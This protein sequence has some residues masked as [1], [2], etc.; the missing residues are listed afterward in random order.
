MLQCQSPTN[1]D[2]FCGGGIYNKGASFD[3]WN[4]LN[5]KR[6]ISPQAK[7]NKERKNSVLYG[8]NAQLFKCKFK[9]DY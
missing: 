6:C 8:E 4:K 3:L 2:C 5:F 9:V 7:T 1:Q